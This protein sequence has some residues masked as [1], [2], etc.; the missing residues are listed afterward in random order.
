MIYQ[1]MCVQ[2]N[3]RAGN[4]AR[5]TEIS[6]KNIKKLIQNYFFLWHSNVMGHFLSSHWKRLR[7]ISLAGLTEWRS[8]YLSIKPNNAQKKIK[9]CKSL[10]FTRHFSYQ[11][12]TSCRLWP[13]V[14]P[15]I[16]KNV[17]AVMT[18]RAYNSSFVLDIH[19]L[20]NSKLIVRNGESKRVGC[21]IQFHGK[22][23]NHIASH[24]I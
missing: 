21:P 12:R 24:F 23:A 1:M 4:R 18:L 13:L 5:R 2:L 9:S 3:N 20:I 7:N 22:L 17:R 14:E 10:P 6:W 8:S 16:C 19:F 11:T 15:Q